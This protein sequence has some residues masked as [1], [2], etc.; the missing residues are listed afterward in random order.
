MTMN[1]KK[2]QRLC[3]RYL[4]FYGCAG[5]A[6]RP[7]TLSKAEKRWIHPMPPYRHT[8]TRGVISADGSTTHHDRAAGEIR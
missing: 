2:L 4:V 5:P 1:D 7:S 3:D 6:F 8:T